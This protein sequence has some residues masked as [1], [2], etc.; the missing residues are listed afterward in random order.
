MLAF[1]VDPRS[2]RSHAMP[3][4]PSPIPADVLGQAAE[5]LRAV[6]LQ[7]TGSEVNVTNG[8]SFQVQTDQT[9]GVLQLV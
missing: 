8:N 6:Y 3:R 4:K 7:M 1:T 5:V 2:Q 9:N